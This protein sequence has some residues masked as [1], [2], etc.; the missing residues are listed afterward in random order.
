MTEKTLSYQDVEVFYRVAGEGK[1][2]VLIHGFAEDGEIWSNQSVYLQDHFRI[3]IPDLPGTG[4]SGMVEHAG[5]ETYAEIIK[6]ILDK[7][8]QQ[9][10]PKDFNEINLIGNIGVE[11]AEAISSEKLSVTMIGHSMGGYITLAF[12]E[13]YPEYLEAFG[14]FH[15]SAFADDDEK[16]QTRRKGIEFINTKGPQAFLKTSIPAMFT[17]G[18]A[19]QKPA[20]VN[21]L[22]EKGN[23]FSAAALVQYYEAMIARPDRTAVLKNFR[24]PILFVMGE[25]DT[26]IPLQSSLQQCYLP[27]QSHVHLLDKS[28]HM[29][30]WEEAEKANDILMK[31]LSAL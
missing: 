7:E 9:A 12:A 25:H 27:A 11:N 18:F 28:A 31:F 13:K 19:E 8:Q 14:L 23:S 16:K 26:A 22:V 6:L 21:G 30:M 2:V 3:I 5:I 29:G 17:R 24:K 20:E 10:G 1:T 4:R 15:S